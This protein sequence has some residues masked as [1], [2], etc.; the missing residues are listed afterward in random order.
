MMAQW[1]SS[2]WDPVISRKGSGFKLT[3]A[4][5]RSNSLVC[6]FELSLSLELDF[7]GF[8]NSLVSFG[9]VICVPKREEE[10]ED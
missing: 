2:S 5:V 4:Q 10:E 8:P 1:F 9:S 3:G 7:G 6:A